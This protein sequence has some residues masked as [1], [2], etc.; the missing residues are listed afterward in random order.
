MKKENDFLNKV[1][2][3]LLL[4]TEVSSNR[5]VYKL[6]NYNVKKIGV[7]RLRNVTY[8]GDY[9][10]QYVKELYGL[11]SSESFDVFIEWKRGI[12]LKREIL[13]TT[14]TDSIPRP[15]LMES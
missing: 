1:V 15:P 5:R 3:D 11:T 2:K 4:E 10:K 14:E 7:L 13:L 6:P 8:S 9:W 12:S